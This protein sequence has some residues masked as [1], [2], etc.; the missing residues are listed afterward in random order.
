MRNRWRGYVKIK[1]IAS[2]IWTLYEETGFYDFMGALEGG[3]EAQANLKLLYERA[4]KYEASGFKG[5]FNFIRYIERM[6]SRNEDIAGAKLVNENHNVVRIMTI[7]KSKGLEFPV[8]FIARTTGKFAFTHVG[9]ENRIT[10][11]KDMGV[12]IDYYNYDDMYCKKLMFSEYINEAN[13]KE[14]LSEEMRLLYVAA[15]RAKEKLI[16][17]AAKGY[18]TYEDYESQKDS[19]HEKYRDGKLSERVAEAAKSYADW[20]IPAVENNGQCWRCEDIVVY[21]A[22]YSEDKAHE[23]EEIK[24]ENVEDVRAAVQKILEFQYAYPLSGQIPAKTSVTAIKEMEDIEH[25]HEDDPVYMTR[26]PAFMREEK[27]GAQIGTAHHQLMAYIDIEKMKSIKEQKYEV[28]VNNEITRVASEGQIDSD[29]AEDTK[30]TDLICKNVCEFFKSDMGKRVLEAKQVYREMPFEIEI[31]AREYDASLGREYENEKVVVQGIID[32]YFEDNNG[33]II[34]VDY[35]T[36]RCGT[37]EEQLAVA[38]K[39]KKQL[40]LYERAMEK[41]LKKSV[42]EKYLYLF[43]AKS[44]IKLDR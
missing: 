5:I 24:I 13:R 6:E 22:D 19:W 43:S 28:F 18:K 8:V 38:N 10:L 1:P 15:T 40:D 11:H 42:R 37:Y 17:T 14:Y 12:G 44:V 41:I 29:M 25:I 26:K 2:L 9:D 32:L 35:K 16:V 21:S 3:E 20:I 31:T 4:K 23:K 34:L 30:I 27:L 36:D 7:H 39:Y 33:D